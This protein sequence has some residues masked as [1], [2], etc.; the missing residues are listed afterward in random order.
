VWYPSPGM[1]GHDWQPVE[2]DKW[3]AESCVIASSQ[4]MRREGR[5]DQLL[6]AEPWDIVVLDEAHHARRRSGGIGPDVR[7]NKLLR[8]MRSLKERTQGL[9]LLT[10][11]PMQVDPIEVW[12][13]LSLLNLPPQW[14]ENSFRRFFRIVEQPNPSPEAFDDLAR[15]FQAAELQY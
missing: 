15:L 8:L 6:K 5:T 13:L 12:D 7:P 10:A 2:A 11:T 9:I 3:H 1:R 14:T 4:L